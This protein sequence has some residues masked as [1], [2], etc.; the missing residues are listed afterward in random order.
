MGRQQGGPW[1]A[2]TK[3]VREKWAS[4]KIWSQDGPPVLTGG[5]LEKSEASGTT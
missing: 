5:R 1:V 2:T 3:Q 4:G